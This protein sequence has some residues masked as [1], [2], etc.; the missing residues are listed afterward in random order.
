MFITRSVKSLILILIQFIC[1]IYIGL[2]G[3]LL[4][5]NIIL[6]VVMAIAGV[7][8]VWAI[9]IMNKKFNVA[10]DVLKNAKLIRIGPYRFIRHPMYL[11]V[12][13][14][15]LCWLIDYFTYVRMSAAIIL[16]VIMIFKIKYEEELLKKAFPEYEEYQ[17]QTKKIIPYIY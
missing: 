10:P 12:F 13:M 15:T 8:A 16:F 4:P 1:I 6:R 7:I 3:R 17:S 5:E 2:S 14:I 9:L 11:S